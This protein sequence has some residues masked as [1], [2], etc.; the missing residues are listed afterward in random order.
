MLEKISDPAVQSPNVVHFCSGEAMDLSANYQEDL[1]R[2]AAKEGEDKVILDS[3]FGELLLKAANA[4]ELVKVVKKTCGDSIVSFAKD[5]TSLIKKDANYERIF[6]L[7]LENANL[8]YDAITRLGGLSL[9]GDNSGK[10]AETLLAQGFFQKQQSFDLSQDGTIRFVTENLLNGVVQN[11]PVKINKM[12]KLGAAPNRAIANQNGGLCALHLAAKIGAGDAMTALLSS[13]YGAASAELKDKKADMTPMHFAAMCSK[14]GSEEL[15]ENIGKLATRKE[16]NTG[17]DALDHIQK[18]P[19]YWAIKSGK[20]KNM[21]ALIEIAIQN[22][23]HPAEE[24]V[25]ALKKY[26]ILHNAAEPLGYLMG[27]S[28]TKADELE[29][30]ITV[31]TANHAKSALEVLLTKED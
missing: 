28:E 16:Q 8:H 22:D 5:F 31:A 11:N 29:K 25:L 9:K 6:S 12:L 23:I 3:A 15:I 24:E 1:A 14:K 19:I 4:E 17:I 27:I 21:E 13:K 26:A 30:L 20:V 18:K 10:L 2:E 7:L